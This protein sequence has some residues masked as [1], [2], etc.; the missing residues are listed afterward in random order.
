MFSMCKKKRP[1]NGDA[2]V[3]STH[4]CIEYPMSKLKTR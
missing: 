1:R 2:F 4:R 3:I